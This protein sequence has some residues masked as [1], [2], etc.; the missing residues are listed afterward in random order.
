MMGAKEGLWQQPRH[1]HIAFVKSGEISKTQTTHHSSSLDGTT[2]WT[3]RLARKKTCFPRCVPDDPPTTRHCGNVV[4]N[5]KEAH[6]HRT[7]S[8]MGDKV[9]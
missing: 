6:R 4:Q 3:W 7:D 2:G 9:F 8:Y 5:R 1:G